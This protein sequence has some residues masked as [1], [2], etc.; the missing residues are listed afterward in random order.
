MN[1]KKAVRNDGLSYFIAFVNKIQN[2]IYSEINAAK[3]CMI[4]KTFVYLH[5]N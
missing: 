5:R 2:D 3:A 4:H 1:R